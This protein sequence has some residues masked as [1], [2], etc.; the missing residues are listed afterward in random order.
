MEN[1]T[2]SIVIPAYDEE[3][4]IGGSLEAIIKAMEGSSYTISLD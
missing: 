1:Q 2:V 4:A 3:E